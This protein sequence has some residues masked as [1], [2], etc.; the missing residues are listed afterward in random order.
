M[1]KTHIYKVLELGVIIVVLISVSFNFHSI[2]ETPTV[3]PTIITVTKEILLYDNIWG[4][5]YNA[6]KRQCD[7][8]PLI[9]GS[10]FRINP[11]KASEHRI[12][13]ISQEML[14]SPY[15]VKLLN[16]PKSD[17]Y[18]G[19]IAYGDTIWIESPH[20][21]INGWWI[22]HDVKNQRYRQSVDFL[23]TK[24][25]SS[26]YNNDPMWNGK[27]DNIKIYRM[28]KYKQTI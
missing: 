9:T 18:K 10:K 7:N 1:K 22:V 2:I 23:Q 19:K 17:L 21:K 12:I 13:A 24:G 26:L 27:F 20:E 15:R 6:E 28:V 25:D 11:N 16:N 3:T 5:I 8:T 4:S 14:N